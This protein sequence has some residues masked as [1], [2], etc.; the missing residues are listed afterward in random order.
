VRCFHSH[1]LCGYC[2]LCFGYFQPGAPELTS[3]AENEL[4]P[5]GAI[6][7][8]FV[9]EP[10]YEYVVDHALCVGCGKCVRGCSMFGNGSLYLQVRHDICVNCNECAIARACPADAF[11]RVPA[12]RP[13]LL[14]GGETA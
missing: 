12:G 2:R 14:K 11:R 7:R 5:T 3:G 9:E 1:A 8:R 6:R 13:Y 10:Y 4:C